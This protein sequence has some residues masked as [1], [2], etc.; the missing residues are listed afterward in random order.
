MVYVKAFR[1]IRPTADRAALVSAPPYDV[2]NR[3]EAKALAAENDFSILHI[4]RAEIDFPDEVDDYD[5]CVYQKG[6]E[7]LLSFLRRKILIQEETPV[8]YIYRER[9]NGT[10]QTGIVGTVAVKDYVEGRV[11][12]HELTRR[13]KEADRI[14][15]FDVCDCQTEPVF[16]TYR[17]RDDIDAVTKDW[18]E[19]HEP[20]FDFQ[21]DDGVSHTLWR[22]DEESAVSA[23]SASFVN[24]DKIYIADGHHRTASAAEVCRKRA[25]D[26]SE[27]PEDD[28]A[29]FILAVI[30][31]DSELEIM[32]YNRIVALPDDFDEERFMGR[33]KEDFLLE[34]AGENPIPQ[35]KHEYGMYLKGVWYRLSAKEHLYQNKDVSENFDASILQKN[36]LAPYFGIDDPR[37]DQRID[38]IG[39]IRGA[40]EIVSR[41]DSENGIGFYLY[42]VAISDLM[43]VS[44]AGKIMPPKSTW[45]EPK[46]RSGLFLHS[47]KED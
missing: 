20:L 14:R 3:K 18:I 10:C 25:A 1:G 4:T 6:K 31:P 35:Q 34:K 17:H 32:A 8:F 39:G 42:P 47:L 46:L 27:L 9:L 43:A 38:F 40:R 7:N 29:R 23:I 19:S 33:L 5:D 36:V 21:S 11:M 44:D 41:C 28:P 30:F 24:I 15:H 45:F 12:K 22:V 2:I 26:E 13:E 37:T 16:L